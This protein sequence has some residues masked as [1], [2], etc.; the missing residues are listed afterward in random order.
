LRPPP[1]LINDEEQYEVEAIRSHR[2]QGRK[3]QLQYL[4]KWKGY[5]ES[6]NI[7]EPADHVRAPQL[8]KQYEWCQ[9]SNIKATQVQPL[10]HPPNWG[11]ADI[12][13]S[14]LSQ[15]GLLPFTLTLHH[16]YEALYTPHTPSPSSSPNVST[17][18][19]HT[20]SPP[21]EH[22]TSPTSTHWKPSISVRTLT[23]P[24]ITETCP[25]RPSIC[26]TSP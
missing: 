15:R 20:S 8:I 9:G 17:G 6:D 18:P 4:I 25:M 19:N 10:H 14:T 5:P 22:A 12:L 7:W 3:K 21:L 11:T 23:A 13:A 1:D 24:H 2:H 26:Q 16:S